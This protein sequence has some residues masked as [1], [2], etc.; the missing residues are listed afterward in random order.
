MWFNYN[1]H[2]KVET[3]HINKIPFPATCS[4]HFNLSLQCLPAKEAT[5]FKSYRVNH[6][7]TLGDHIGATD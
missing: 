4:S 6:I 5:D 3:E 1:L 2:G 7:A